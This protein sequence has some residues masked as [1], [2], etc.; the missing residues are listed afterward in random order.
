M[1]TP[2]AAACTCK[3]CCEDR[4]AQLLVDAV[5]ERDAMT[6]REAAV[7]AGARSDAEVAQ[8]EQQI[9]AD[10]EVALRTPA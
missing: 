3:P 10:R 9:R 6:P 7:A 5:A 8:L 2:H 4:C 1:S